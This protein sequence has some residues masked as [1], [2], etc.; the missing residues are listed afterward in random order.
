MIRGLKLFVI[1][2]AGR[3][4][5]ILAL[6]RIDFLRCPRRRAWRYNFCLYCLN[7]APPLTNNLLTFAL[8]FH[9]GA[10][11]FCMECQKLIFIFMQKKI[12]S[13]LIS[14]FYKD[15]LESLVKTLAAQN[16]TIYSTGGTLTISGTEAMNNNP[17]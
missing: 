13:T 3:N 17:T 11:R 15:G 6:Q 2:T 1:S 4:L 7:V 16:V 5:C 8:L 9:S 14:V 12:S 10:K